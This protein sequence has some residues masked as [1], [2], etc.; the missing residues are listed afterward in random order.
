MVA[1]V[2]HVVNQSV[3]VSLIAGGQRTTGAVIGIDR[4][5]DLALVRPASP[6]TGQA[7][8]LGAKLPAVGDAAVAIGFSYGDPITL[9]QGHISGLDRRIPIDGAIRSG[10]I[11]T[12]TAI[13]PGN[14]GGPLI[15][16]DGAAVGLVDAGSTQANGIG[17][18]VPA[19]IAAS[20]MSTWTGSPQALAPT[21]CANPLGPSQTTTDIPT[22]DQIDNQAAACRQGTGSQRRHL[23][24]VDADLH[25][26]PQL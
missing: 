8:R 1:T 6:L 13:N 7:F 2:A 11:E 18:A 12:D 22:P 17:Y 9:T 26:D 5:H 25:D 3:V 16:A 15:A 4:T 23:R 21:A 24:R 20:R 19:G 14:S 10:L